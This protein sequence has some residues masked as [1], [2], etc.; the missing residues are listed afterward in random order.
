MQLY[1]L[2][3]DARAVADAFALVGAQ[4]PLHP[5]WR[6]GQAAWLAVAGDLEQARHL[7]TAADPGVLVT[8]ERNQYAFGSWAH[9]AILA[10]RLGEARLGALAAGELARYRAQW[11]QVGVCCLGPVTRYLGL[12]LAAQGRNVEAIECYE[13]ADAALAE[14]GL[15]VYRPFVA[16]D[17]TRAQA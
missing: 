6:L 11:V 1:F 13:Q 8:I 2:D 7:L 15:E 14:R 16:A 3:G 10:D 17:L 9:L 12:A 4:Q 5:R